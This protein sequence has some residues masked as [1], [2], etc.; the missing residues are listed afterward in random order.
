MLSTDQT[1][2]CVDCGTEFVFTASEQ[3]FYTERGFSPPK[4]CKACRA[5]AKARQGGGGGAGAPGGFS[6][7]PRGERTMYQTTCAQCGAETEVPF[8]PT[9]S[10]PVL[11]RTC[12]R[13]NQ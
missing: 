7:A 10:R 6:G 12:F 11:C 4:R 2:T 5:A 1:L 3:A 13:Q 8:R 9:G